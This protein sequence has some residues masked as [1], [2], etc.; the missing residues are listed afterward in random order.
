MHVLG[1]FKKGRFGLA[2]T[3]VTGDRLLKYTLVDSYMRCLSKKSP[4]YATFKTIKR[5]DRHIIDA[6]LILR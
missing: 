1:V 4:W 3:F 6:L 5:D 2:I